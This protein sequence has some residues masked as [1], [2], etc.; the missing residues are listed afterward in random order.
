MEAFMA[1]T[2]RQPKGSGSTERECR[3]CGS[4]FHGKASKEYCSTNCQQAAKQKRY[5]QAKAGTKQRRYTK[6][7]DRFTGSSFGKWLYGELQRS[8]TVQ[9]LADN[10]AETLEELHRLHRL[11]SRYSGYVKGKPSGAYHFAHIHPVKAT[12]GR[13]GLIHP[14]NLVIAPALWNQRH[15]ARPPENPEQVGRYIKTS[16]L[17]GS[18]WQVR[19]SDKPARCW[20]LLEKLLGEEWTCFVA[21]LVITLTQAQALR[22]KLKKQGYTVPDHYSLD[23]LKQLAD[24]KALSYFTATYDPTD[25]HIVAKAELERM[26]HTVGTEYGVYLKWLEALDDTFYGIDGQTTIDQPLIE[27]VLVGESFSILHGV[28]PPARTQRQ[29]AAFLSFTAAPTSTTAQPQTHG[30]SSA[31]IEEEQ[32]N[33]E[34]D[35]L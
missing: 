22:N 25:P 4:L 29:Q 33:E 13:I 34:F 12:S 20:K 23:E 11:R 8:G 27:Q 19:E 17:R 31:S 26:G 6:K 9:V 21:T 15:G 35:L 18:V 1:A 16:D 5:R 7:I 24:S 3:H 2:K 10:T 30:Q 28:T 14:A 32:E